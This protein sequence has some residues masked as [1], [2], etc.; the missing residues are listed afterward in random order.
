MKCL[1]PQA[2]SARTGLTIIPEKAST[3]ILN[4]P[5]ESD[6]GT[7]V[8]RRS[9]GRC[10]RRGVIR[11]NSPALRKLPKIQRKNSRGFIAFALQL[12]L[13]NREGRIRA[14]HMDF[15]CQKRK[16]PHRLAIRIVFLIPLQHRLPPARDPA[17]ADKGSLV[18][19]PVSGHERINIPAIPCLG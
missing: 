4:A 11:H 3:R 17:R 15:K 8:T 18:G 13:T 9:A 7:S 12:K 5:A 6:L 16:L 10:E 19:L 2:G 14:D 1:L